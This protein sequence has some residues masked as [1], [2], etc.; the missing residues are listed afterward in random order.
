MAKSR[1]MKSGVRAG[2]FKR[3]R[4]GKGWLAHR[5]ERG[6]PLPVDRSESDDP[7]KSKRES[8]ERDDS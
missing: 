5:K 7:G 2:K 3:K 1:R 8:S 6:R 4:M